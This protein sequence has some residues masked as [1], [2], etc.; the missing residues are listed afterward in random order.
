MFAVFPLK[1]KNF[2]F[3]RTLFVSWFLFKWAR[4]R[5]IKRCQY[6]KCIIVYSMMNWVAFRSGCSENNFNVNNLHIFSY[7]SCLPLAQILKIFANCRHQL[8]FVV[9]F[10]ADD[11][12]YQN[13]LQ[14]P[15]LA[16][17]PCCYFSK[18]VRKSSTKF[19]RRTE[20]ILRNVE[21][22]SVAL[23]KIA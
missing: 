9:A 3:N 16:R 20:I 5:W 11:G 18:S 23:A 10:W 22:I 15:I 14:T 6:F 21:D 4:S 12:K 1:K 2:F 7:V 8:N 19:H 13:I 17:F